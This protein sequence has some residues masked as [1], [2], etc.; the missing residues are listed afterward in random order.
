MHGTTHR[1]HR[2]SFKPPTDHHQS[3]MS[4]WKEATPEETDRIIEKLARAIIEREMDMP[5]TL[6]LGSLRPVSYF[7]GQMLR[8]FLA[9]FTPL[10]GDLPYEYIYVLEQPENVK[11]LIRRVDEL[12]EEKETKKRDDKDKTPKGEE[13]KS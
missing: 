7:G 12:R 9:P 11:R 4:I 5:A 2:K 13:P 8:F 6:L 1:P 3:T 10:L